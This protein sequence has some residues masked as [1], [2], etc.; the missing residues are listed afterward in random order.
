MPDSNELLAW[1]DDEIETAASLAL[2]HKIAEVQTAE[3]QVYPPIT[4]HLPCDLRE[5]L[6]AALK[7]SGST[8]SGNFILRAIL[9]AIRKEEILCVRPA[10]RVPVVHIFTDDGRANAT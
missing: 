6:K 2:D 4:L 8:S 5:R 1:L 10:E 7:S 9:I 3:R